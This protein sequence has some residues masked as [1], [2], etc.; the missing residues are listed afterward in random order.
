MREKNVVE[1]RGDV[2][3]ENPVSYMQKYDITTAGR[4]APKSRP[5]TPIKTKMNDN[6]K[7][8]PARGFFPS[9]FPDGVR[10]LRRR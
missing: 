2:H 5:R 6:Q 4:S 1:R 3:K 8:K 9:I 10:F 7:E